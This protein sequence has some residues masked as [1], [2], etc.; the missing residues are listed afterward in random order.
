MSIVSSVIYEDKTQADGTRDIVEV[1]TD[2]LGVDHLVFLF[3]RASDYDESVGMAAHVTGI[4]ESLAWTEDNSAYGRIESGDGVL[5]VVNSPVHS[6]AKRIA[7]KLLYMLM[8]SKNDEDNL[9]RMVVLLEPL[10]AYLQANY[11]GSQLANFLD[12]TVGQV[13]KMNDKRAALLLAAADVET[14]E[15]YNEEVG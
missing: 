13:S 7:K 14:A 6:T 2:H 12:I 1:H 9:V 10:L 8:R 3:G 15:T 11:N 5:D 4:E